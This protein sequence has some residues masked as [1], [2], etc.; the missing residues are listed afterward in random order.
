DFTLAPSYITYPMPSIS[1]SAALPSTVDVLLN[2]RRAATSNVQPGPFELTDVP[3]VTGA[4]Q[5]Q[6]VVRDLLGRETVVSQSYYVAPVLLASGLSDF[7]F[8]AGSL[9]ENYGTR[10]DDYGSGF[11]AGTYRLGITDLLTAGARVEAQRDRGA[12]GVDI[13]MIVSDFAVI[14]LA[15]G[16]SVADGEHGGHYVASVQRTTRLGGVSLSIEHFD[17]GYSQFGETGTQTGSRDISTTPGAAQWAPITREPRPKDQVAAQGG[18]SIGTRTTV[19]MSLTEQTSWEGDRFSLLGVNLGMQLPGNVYLGVYSS[20]ELSA[21][22]TWSGGLTVTVPIGGRRTV[23]A[24]ST[25]DAGGQLVDTVQATQTVPSGPGWG[26]HVAASDDPTQRLLAGATYNGAYGQLTAEADAGSGADAVR[27]GANGSLEWMEGHVFASRRIDEGAF[28]VVHVGDVEGVPVSLSNQVIAVTDHHGIAL[29]TGLLPYQANALTLDPEQL[30]LDV[31]IGGVRETVV[32]YARSGA[33]VNFPVKRS[34]NASVVLQQPGGAPVPAGA[35]VT[36]TPGNQEFVVA[37][38][39]EVY[40]ID[41]AKD[42]R[43]DVRWKDGGCVLTIRMPP[44]PTDSEAVRIGP[45]M[46]GATK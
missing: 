20:K 25:R 13:A 41:L 33:F 45:L 39:G 16:Y 24:S 40:L 28:A 3:I 6:L 9:R 11:G 43:I 34:R 23:A 21:G 2:D 44:L 32:P 5:M 38:R 19:G 1:G 36:M 7:S 15:M 29:V 27:L 10:S 26:W 12:A 30:P 4:G 17:A 18:I 14:G 37:K 31:E 46:C 42:N 35:R 22:K 8:E